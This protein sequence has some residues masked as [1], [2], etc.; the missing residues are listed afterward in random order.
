[1]YNI[2]GSTK[3]VTKTTTRRGKLLNIFLS[4]GFWKNIPQFSGMTQ[5]IENYKDYGKNRLTDSSENDPLKWVLLKIFLLLKSTLNICYSDPKPVFHRKCTLNNDRHK[6]LSPHHEEI[7]NFI[8]E[9]KYKNQFLKHC[10]L[11]I[12]YWYYVF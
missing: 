10:C 12:F 4:I 9:C 11:L 6:N 8:F 7:V 1:M 2:K 3:M 5:N